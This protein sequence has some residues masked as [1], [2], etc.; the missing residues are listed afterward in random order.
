M[1]I[2]LSA[3]LGS[4]YE[5]FFKNIIY[6]IFSNWSRTQYKPQLKWKK[7]VDRSQSDIKWNQD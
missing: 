6:S 1:S 5:Q 4:K 7:V 2:Y 3:K